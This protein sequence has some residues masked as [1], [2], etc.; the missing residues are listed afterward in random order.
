MGKE[1]KAQIKMGDSLD[2]AGIS[3][4]P[5][6]GWEGRLTVR[7]ELEITRER[8]E[9]LREASTRSKRIRLKSNHDIRFEAR[10]AMVDPEFEG[11]TGFRLKDHLDR[12][13][14]R[15]NS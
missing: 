7:Q 9:E 1:V 4:H 3:K 13:S 14:T 11:V 10:L 15:L 5:R 12:K 8:F 2:F 6:D